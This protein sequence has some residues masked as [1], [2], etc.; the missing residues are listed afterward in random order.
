[1]DI[2]T[3]RKKAIELAHQAVIFD[4]NMNYKE[5]IQKFTEACQIMMFV[6]KCIFFI[7]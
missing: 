7:R 5:A 6:I 1:M 3:Q 4:D 2:A